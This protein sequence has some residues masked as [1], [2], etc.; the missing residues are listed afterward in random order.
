[1]GREGAGGSSEWKP[2]RGHES[3]EAGQGLRSGM[4]EVGALQ[5]V[6][7]HGVLRHGHAAG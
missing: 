4:G 6:L 1:M 5:A 7:R 3:S 2:Y